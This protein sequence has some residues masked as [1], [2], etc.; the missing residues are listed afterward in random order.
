MLIPVERAQI[1]FAHQPCNAMLAAGLAGFTQ[2]EEHA[3]GAI[4]AV[5][6]DR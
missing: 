6:R 5:T 2:I 4:D 1:V 3:D